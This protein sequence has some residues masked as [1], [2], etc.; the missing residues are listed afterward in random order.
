MTLALLPS[1]ISSGETVD[2]AYGFGRGRYF[3]SRGNILI[4]PGMTGENHVRPRKNRV[5]TG[6]R[7]GDIPI[8][9]LP[10]CSV[11]LTG[12]FFFYEPNLPQMP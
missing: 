12:L 6:I 10:T 3:S 11:Y 7:V 4:L 5:L 8:T 9:R 2:E 1:I